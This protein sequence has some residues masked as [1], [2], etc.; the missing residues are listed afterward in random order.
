MI[1]AADAIKDHDTYYL[2]YHGFSKRYQVG[3]AT[4]SHPLGPWKKHDKNPVLRVGPEDSWDQVHVA[5]AFVLKEKTDKYYM[6]YSGYGRAGKWGIGL[7]TASSPLGP[8]KKHQDNPIMEH[9]GYVGGVVRYE[10]K[11]Y[12]YTAHPIGST[13]NDYSPMSL[14]IA[15]TPEGPYEQYEGNPVLEPDPWGS[16]DDGGFSEA[17]V[18]YHDGIFHMFYGAA[19]LHPTRILSRESIGYAYSLDGRHFTKYPKNPVATREM[20]PDGGA[21][22]EVHALAEGPFIYL[23]HTLRYNS[24]HGAEDLGV[25]VLAT[26]R[27]FKLRMPILVNSSIEP[28][29]TTPLNECRPL[30]LDNISS[31]MITAECKYSGKSSMPLRIH[32]RASYDGLQYDTVD[33]QVIELPSRPGTTVRQTAEVTA[34]VKYLKVRVENPDASESVSDVII[35]AT[36][37]G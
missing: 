33:M 2:Y 4:A 11:Y 6:W 36:L 15:E 8:W 16:W 10:G 31:L 9:F 14:A 35:T 5:C 12:L 19:K 21:F 7:A 22:A 18:Y 1:E 32:V 28:G 13:G 17:E 26:Q 3:V 25:Q 34:K 24:R 30:C 27:P 37:A 20:I 23:F 29:K